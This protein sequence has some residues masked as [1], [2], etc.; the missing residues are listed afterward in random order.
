M[1]YTPE[2]IRDISVEVYKMRLEQ[3]CKGNTERMLKKDN[4]GGVKLR[5]RAG[6]YDSLTRCYLKVLRSDEVN[7]GTE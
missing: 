2:Q 5:G 7:K 1:K 6:A 3:D 4:D